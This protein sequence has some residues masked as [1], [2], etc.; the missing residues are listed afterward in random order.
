VQAYIL[1]KMAAV[2]GAEDALD[3]ADEVTEQMPRDELEHATQVL[4]Q[5][6]RKYLLELQNA[7]GRTPFSLPDRRPYHTAVR[8]ADHYGPGISRARAGPTQ[9]RSTSWQFRGSG[10][11]PRSGRHGQ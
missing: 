2:N 5:I 7:E 8:N 4:G 11:A 6:F 3:M 1:L 9:A 10:L